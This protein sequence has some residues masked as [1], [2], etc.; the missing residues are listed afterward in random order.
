MSLVAVTLILL[1]SSVCNANDLSGHW[2]GNWKS[3]KSGHKGVLRAEFCKLNETQY[4]VNFSG[5]FFKIMPFRYSVVLNVIEEGDSVVLAGKSN[6]GRIMGTF[7]YNAT[8]T[9]NQFQSSY[10]SCK[11]YGLFTLTK[12][13]CCN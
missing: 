3:C 8:V 9:G 6:L 4:Q 10:N 5:R 12:C 11:D 2:E 7:T 13:G 1:A